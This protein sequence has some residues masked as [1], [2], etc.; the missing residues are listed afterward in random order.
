MLVAG[1]QSWWM[2][3]ALPRI[4]Q[5]RTP[6]DVLNIAKWRWTYVI[7]IASNFIGGC[8]HQTRDSK[9]SFLNG[10]PKFINTFPMLP[11]P[12]PYSE[13]ESLSLCDVFSVWHLVSWLP[14]WAFP[15][16]CSTAGK[17]ALWDWVPFCLS[18]WRRSQIF[19]F[20]LSCTYDNPWYCARYIC[21][22]ASCTGHNISRCELSWEP[23]P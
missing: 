14:S 10:S 6:G 7:I 11:D 17:T 5:E 22:H 2:R 12:I 15:S 1:E 19:L 18:W 13:S 20:C 21:P 4:I 23:C 3:R 16:S 9:L 8:F